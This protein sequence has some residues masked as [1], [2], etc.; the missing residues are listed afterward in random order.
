MSVDTFENEQE[1]M[2][3]NMISQ[4]GTQADFIREELN[5]N[6]DAEDPVTK[7]S[8]NDHSVGDCID[9]FGNGQLKKTVIKKGENGTRPNRGDICTLNITGKLEDSKIVEEYENLVI[10]LGDLE[11]IQGLDLAIA[12]MDIGE[13]AEIVI[14]PR[15]A[16]GKQGKKPIPPDATII[17]TVELKAAELEPEIEKLSISQRR[18]TSNKKRE[19]GNWWFVRD[20]LPF[21][22]QCYRKALEYL[23]STKSGTNQNEEEESFSDTELQ[24]LLE[25]RIKVHNNLAAALIKTEA[26]D[27][28][29]ENVEHVLRCQPQNVKALF[30][31]GTILRLKGEY[32][33]AYAIF[34][35]MQKLNPDMKICNTELMTLKDKIAKDAKK[36]KY[37]YRKMLGVTEDIKNLSKDVK[38]DDKSKKKFAKGVLWTLAGA[39]S[40][41]VIS[42]FIHR[43]TS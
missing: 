25:D 36:E 3:E 18:E 38:A 5:F 2:D 23:S 9:I 31:K 24:I 19:R 43:F 20:E 17:Y 37:L 6:I 21:A 39:A 42:V 27:S 4:G 10:Q 28:A 35:E 26:Y 7:A 11:V 32:A 29:L 40:A 12:L 8:L 14:D 22:L 1:K 13:V 41:V 30:R 34:T 33:K 16:Y 15:F